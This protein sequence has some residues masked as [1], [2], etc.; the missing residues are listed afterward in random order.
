MLARFNLFLQWYADE[1]IMLI[2]FKSKY[3]IYFCYFT[4]VELKKN[5][6]KYTD[7]LITSVGLNTVSV[8]DEKKTIVSSKKTILIFDM[9]NKKVTKKYFI[10]ETGNIVGLFRTEK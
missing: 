5:K 4:G 1:C 8:F 10:H 6:F 9:K 7:L 3:L 2:M